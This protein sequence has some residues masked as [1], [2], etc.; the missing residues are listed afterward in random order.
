MFA[1]ALEAGP[2]F[3]RVEL[4]RL[5]PQLAPGGRSAAVRGEEWRRERLFAAVAELL[6]VVAGGSRVGLVI[7]DVHWADSATLDCLTFLARARAGS[8]VTVVATCHR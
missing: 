1:A 6:A 8:G 2:P 7:E 4:E 3:V 5:L